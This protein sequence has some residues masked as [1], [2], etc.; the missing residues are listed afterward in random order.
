MRRRLV[1]TVGLMKRRLRVQPLDPMRER[2]VHHRAGALGAR[3][4]L[5]PPLAPALMDLLI[6]DAH[7]QQGIVELPA[8]QPYQG[9]IAM[10]TVRSEERRVGKECVS[11]FRCL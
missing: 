9:R 11:P 6:A 7:A 2:A 3:L 8:P 5:P 1:E 4:G 10:T